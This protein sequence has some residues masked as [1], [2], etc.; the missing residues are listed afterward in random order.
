MVLL[1]RSMLSDSVIMRRA[2][3]AEDWLK[4]EG[5]QA[6]TEDSLRLAVWIR[7]AL[8]AGLRHSGIGV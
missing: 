1:T 5:G 7:H 8:M 6:A 2:R 3:D 4:C